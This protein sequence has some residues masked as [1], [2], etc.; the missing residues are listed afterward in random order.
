MMAERRKIRLWGEPRVRRAGMD[1]TETMQRAIIKL[2]EETFGK[3]VG[4]MTDEELAT[5]KRH[6]RREG[7]TMRFTSGFDHDDPRRTQGI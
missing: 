6:I 2:V 1:R 4:E 7:L 3:P 5:L